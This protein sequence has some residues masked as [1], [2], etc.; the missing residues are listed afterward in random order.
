MRQQRIKTIFAVLTAVIITLGLSISLR[1]L[2]AGVWI[3]PTD[4]PPGNNVDAPLNVGGTFQTKGGPLSIYSSTGIPLTLT[5]TN[6]NNNSFLVEDDTSP[7]NT[8]FVIDA[9]G[10][11][12]IG[13]A[14]PTEKLVVSGNVKVNRLG[15]GGLD[16]NNYILD[17]QNGNVR[18]ASNGNI[19]FNQGSGNATFNGKTNFPGQGVWNANGNVGIGTTDPTQKLDING[20]IRIRG[21]VPIA[22]KVLMADNNT[23]LASWQN[24]PVLPPGTSGQTLRHNGTSWVANDTIYNNGTNVGIGTNNPLTIL[25]IGGGGSDYTNTN[26]TYQFYSSSAKKIQVRD[27]SQ[28]VLNLVSNIDTENGVLGAISFSRSGGQADAHRNV[29]GIRAIQASGGTAVTRGGQLEFWTK[30]SGGGVT[31]PR[32]VINSTGYVGIGTNNPGAKLEINGNVRTTPNLSLPNLVLDSISSGDDW[33]SQGAYISL[34]ESGALGSAA[35]HLTYV[36]NGYGYIGSGAVNAGI[37]AQSYLRFQYNSKNIY[38]DSDLEIYGNGVGLYFNQFNAADQYIRWHV[39]GIRWWTMGP[40]ANG[41]FW[42]TNSFDHLNAGPLT[43]LNNGNV[44]IGTPS[45]SDKLTVAGAIRT[46]NDS[47]GSLILG[48]MDNSNEGGEITWTAAGSYPTWTQDVYQNEMRFFVNSSNNN[49]RVNILNAGSGSANLEVEGNVNARQLCINNTCQASWPSAGV[50]GSGSKNNIAMW[51]SGNTL[52]N[53]GIRYSPSHWG[54]PTFYHFDANLD[55]SSYNIFAQYVYAAAFYYQS[56]QSLKKNLHIIQNPIGKLEKLNGYHF[57]WKENNEPSL[58]FVA[59]EVEK[60]FPEAV[61]EDSR[62]GLKSVNYGILVAPLWEAVKEQQKLI[63]SMQYEIN[64]LKK[65][66]Q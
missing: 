59:Q 24:L 49:S 21:G 31:L 23:G 29:A 66:N 45:P 47:A 56:D 48:R 4:T 25:D 15:I 60:V 28:S 38:T 1:S 20:Q 65:H 58:G 52:T 53:S 5:N 19:N 14:Y 36:G 18:M 11:V 32:L 16:A 39:P 42:I 50:S 26:T 17:V 8:P 2:L 55:V 13:T 34:G 27:I 30:P 37:P 3:A 6:N 40:K 44:G 9:N 51:G 62:T 64:E 22:G 41:D 12:G 46:T 61:Q 54:N 7:D 63:K 57:F 33:T 10:N 43:I 35:L